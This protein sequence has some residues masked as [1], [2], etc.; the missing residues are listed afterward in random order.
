MLAVVVP[1]H[2][3]RRKPALNGNLFEQQYCIGHQGQRYAKE[4]RIHV[5]SSV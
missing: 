1:S 5:S 2:S 4:S 3:V